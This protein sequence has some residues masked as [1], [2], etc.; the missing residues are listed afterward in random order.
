MKYQAIYPRTK[1]IDP[2]PAV[3][4]FMMQDHMP[5]VNLRLSETLDDTRLKYFGKNTIR[6]L[7]IN[8]GSDSED[9]FFIF[10][11]YLNFEDFKY[12]GYFYPNFLLTTA[13]D[14]QNFSP[15][16]TIDF[17]KK[18]HGANC[19]MNKPRPARVL[20][21]CWFANNK[22]DQLLH[23]QSWTSTDDNALSL[24]DELLQ[25]GGLIDWTHEFGPHVKMLEQHWIDHIGNTPARFNENSSLEANFFTTEISEIF[26]STAISVVLEPVFW[27]HGSIAS[28]KYMHAI[29]GGTI[30]LVSGYKIYDSLVTLGFDT[31]SDIIDTSS[32]YEL[33]PILQIWTMLEKN[34]RLFLQWQEL[35]SD[36]H[37]QNRI[38]KNLTL[39]QNPEQIFMNSLKLNSEQSLNKILV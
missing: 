36:P 26:N 4:F 2:D 15:N 19:V 33:D 38:L 7:F 24:L 18:T 10:D 39:L 20:A 3:D 29:Y 37:I 8:Q 25:M 23:T 28:E 32:Q 14:Y 11:T 31:F 30:P 6:D 35:I 12:N 17:K 34:K 27:E 16:H 5:H 13:V 22:V 9:Y 21:S 1:A